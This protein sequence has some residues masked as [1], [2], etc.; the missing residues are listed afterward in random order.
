MTDYGFIAGAVSAWSE[1]RQVGPYVVVPTFSMYPSNSVVQAYIEGGAGRFVVSDGGGA[2]D[3]LL[4]VGGYKVAGLKLLKDFARL[5]DLKINTSGWLCSAPAE[6]ETLTSAISI[7]SDAS[8]AAA[9]MLIKHFKPVSHSDFRKEIEASLELRFHESF[10]KRAHFP[11]ASNKTHTYDYSI[12]LPNGG[13]F[14]IDAVVPDAGSINAAVVAHMDLRAA[15]RDDV[16]QAI[17]YNDNQEWKSSDLALLSIGAP[18]IAYTKFET[19]M[20]RFLA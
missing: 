5:R 14:I 12:R 18:T 9:E 4:G 6:K 3:T 16:R 8:R 20:E 19:A 15:N 1:P 17:V 13:T 11:G 2:I 10:S 7:V